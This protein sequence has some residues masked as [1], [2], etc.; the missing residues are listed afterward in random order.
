LRKPNEQEFITDD[1]R[2]VRFVS[3]FAEGHKLNMRFKVTDMIYNGKLE[4]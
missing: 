3:E 1:T 4:Y 2:E